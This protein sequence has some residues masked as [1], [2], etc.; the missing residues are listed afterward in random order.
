MLPLLNSDI[1]GN[2]CKISFLGDKAYYRSAFYYLESNIT[3]PMMSLSIRDSEMIADIHKLY[4]DFNLMFYNTKSSIPRMFCHIDNIDF[5][6]ISR[7]DSISSTITAQMEKVFKEPEFYIEIDNFYKTI[8]LSTTLT[9]YTGD[10]TLSYNIEDKDKNLLYLDLVS[11]RGQSR[12]NF[13]MIDS[14]ITKSNSINLKAITLKKLLQ[15]FDLDSKIGL[16]F[17]DACI[18]IV[19]D[20]IKALLIH[21]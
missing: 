2:L 17:S 13:D 12:F 18:T 4:P 21:I 19:N 6:F 14:K 1:Q 20:N 11:S 16:G 8:N 5:L 3:T 15:S 10:I 7:V 9:T